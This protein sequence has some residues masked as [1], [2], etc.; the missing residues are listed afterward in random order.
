ME[1]QCGYL[2]LNYQITKLPNKQ[3]SESLIEIE[4]LLRLF[5]GQQVRIVGWNGRV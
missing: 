4:I 5:K 3:Y 2:K 1:E